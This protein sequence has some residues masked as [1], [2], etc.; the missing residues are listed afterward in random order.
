M[1]KNL[2]CFIAICFVLLLS[3]STFV[4]CAQETTINSTTSQ[5]NSTTTNSIDVHVFYGEGCPHCAQLHSYLEEVVQTYPQLNII[6]H[7]VYFNDEE[8]ELFM[9]M[10]E[11]YGEEIQGVPTIFIGNTVLVGWSN[12]IKGQFIEE[13]EQRCVSSC[14]DPLTNKKNN[15]TVIVSGDS[16]STEDDQKTATRNKLT[17]GAVIG[18]ALVDAINPCAFAVLIILLTTIIAGGKKPK[19][20]LFSGI[21]FSLAIFISYFLMGLGLYTVVSSTGLGHG[22]FWVVAILAILIGLLNLKDFLW[23]GKWFVVEVPPSWRPKMKSLIKGITSV[24]GAF[25]IGFVVSLFLLPC[26]SGPYIVILGLLAKATTKSYALWMLL[27]Y[28]IIFILPMVLISVGVSLGITNLDKTERLRKRNLKRLHLIAGIII[29]LLGI[30]MI[31][32]LSTG[33]L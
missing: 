2:L 30:G 32:A 11:S 24:P 31:I 10:S 17:L 7:E 8:R 3:I 21:A 20:A 4:V 16:S 25:A 22:F 23:Y 33:M 1:K 19:K 27:L 9:Q 28:N 13:I 14:E 26:T 12:S 5:V 18:A 15:E 29:L 6:N